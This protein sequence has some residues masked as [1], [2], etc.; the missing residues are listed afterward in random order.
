MGL[1]SKAV[2]KTSFD[3]TGNVLTAKTPAENF[4]PN[5][6]EKII[7]DFFHSSA[8]VVNCCVFNTAVNDE[9]PRHI[10]QAVKSFGLLL[11]LRGN[12]FI[13]LFPSSIDHELLLHHL[14]KH[15]RLN[16]IEQFSTDTP[17][18]LFVSFQKYR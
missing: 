17:Q 5:E 16:I 15:F 4:K 18:K 6:M 11:H 12:T 2:S 10:V 14:D 9:T 8:G 7:T 3:E 13:L 1:L